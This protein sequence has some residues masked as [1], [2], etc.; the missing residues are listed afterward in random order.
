MRRLILGFVA[1]TSCLSACCVSAEHQVTLVYAADLP[2][3]GAPN[4]GDYAELA[5]LLEQQRGAN[6]ENLLFVFG[7]ASLAPSPLASFDSGSHIVDILNNLEPDVMSITKR[8]FSY[9]EDELILRSYEAAFP[10]LLSN[11][12]DKETE[13]PLD[14]IYTDLIVNKQNANIG[15][16]SIVSQNITAEYLLKR[17]EIS[18]PEQAVMNIS[19][20]LRAEG[21]DAIV[22]LH[23]DMFD[24]IKPA[25]DQGI[26]D[27]SIQSEPNNV[28]Q[29]IP[30]DERHPNQLVLDD[31][32]AAAVIEVHFS[33]DAQNSRVTVEKESIEL[34]SLVPNPAI[35]QI[36]NRYQSRLNTQLKQ[37]IAT[38]AEPFDTLRETVRTKESGFGNFITDAMRKEG[39][40]DIALI[41]SGVI[42]GDRAYSAGYPFTRR[43]LLHELPFRA[44]LV[45]IEVTGQDIVA[46]LENGVSQYEVT[47]GRFPQV[48]GLSFSIDVNAPVNQ[49]ITNVSVDG[50]PVQSDKTYI[51]ATSDYL[52]SGGDGYTMFEGATRRF[53]N[54][55]TAPLVSEVVSRAMQRADRVN[56]VEQGRITF[57]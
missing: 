36:I 45:V 5:T 11:A 6:R 32:G 53:E 12:T 22:L 48:S 44:R 42:R 39:Q 21:A 29:V 49:R 4:H 33:H 8:E 54:A 41:N 2:I 24:F 14:G 51:L 10:L 17:L 18:S 43:D 56:L 27:I 31:L 13:Q 46:A 28:L 23:S 57:D 15:F 1:L 3:I 50:A 47:K 7:G 9:F 37:Q 16:I 25:L 40:A 30:I 34:A 20:Q 19:K 26:I 55:P 35:A 38:I 52:F